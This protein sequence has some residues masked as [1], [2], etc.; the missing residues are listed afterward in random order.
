M[1]NKFIDE[2]DPTHEG[3]SGF[4]LMIQ[5][6][7]VFIISK[8]NEKK[9]LPS[10][11]DW[12]VIKTIPIPEI[13]ES[14]LDKYVELLSPYIDPE[15]KFL[16]LECIKPYFQSID[17]KS[18]ANILY[19]GLLKRPVEISDIIV[20]SNLF[21]AKHICDLIDNHLL[22]KNILIRL[23]SADK[24]IYTSEDLVFMKDIC[25]KL[26]NLPDIRNVKTKKGLFVSEKEVS[27]CSCGKTFDM[28]IE[29]CPHCSK[30][31]KGFLKKQQDVIDFF[32]KKVE[33]LEGLLKKDS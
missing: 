3:I 30:N 10:E 2:T 31:N 11:D 23:L 29:Y 14:L 26:H 1:E 24:A 17:T 28:N 5:T 13:G 18:A 27:E 8:I 7:K 32:M 21:S 12:A 16:F 19:A 33:I 4:N 25:T 15:G 9:L 6:K 22:E 20:E